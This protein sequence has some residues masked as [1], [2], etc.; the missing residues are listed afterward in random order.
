LYV[1]IVIYGIFLVTRLKIEYPALSCGK[2]YSAA[3]N[4][5]AAEPP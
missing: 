3:E 5:A 2:G 4:L 1:F